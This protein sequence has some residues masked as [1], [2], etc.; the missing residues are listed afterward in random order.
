MVFL[1]GKA[2]EAVLWCKETG[3][4]AGKPFFDHV[5]KRVGCTV[6]W[7]FNEG[8]K[9]DATNGKVKVREA[10]RCSNGNVFVSSWPY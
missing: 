4:L 9:I 5:F 3:V 8:D 1:G 7:L 10:A 2:E 6:E